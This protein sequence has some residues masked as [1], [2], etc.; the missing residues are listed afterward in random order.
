MFVDV[1]AFRARSLEGPW[2]AA[3]TIAP[4]GT[5]T[6]NSQSGFTLTLEGT[7]Q[8]THLYLGDHVCVVH[9]VCKRL[10]KSFDSVGPKLVMGK[11]IYLAAGGN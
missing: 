2:S 3:F 11:P 1:V 7:E 10:L 4:L 6:Y 8:T 9:Q 5:R